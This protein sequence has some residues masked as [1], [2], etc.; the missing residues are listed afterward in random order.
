LLVRALQNMAEY[1]LY[2]VLAD[3]GYGLAPHTRAERA[4]A[5]TYKHATWLAGLPAAA[6]A[7]LQALTAQFTRAGTDGLENPQV[8]Q[9]PRVQQAGGLAALRAL[10][11]PADV[12]RETKERLFAA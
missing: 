4:E 7:T 9:L 5:F 10:G 3:L 2:D 8:F 1:D 6:A 12:L 11:R